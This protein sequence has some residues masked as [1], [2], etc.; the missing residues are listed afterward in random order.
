MKLGISYTPRLFAAFGLLALVGAVGLVSSRPARTAGGPIA[1]SVANTPL[2]VSSADSRDKQV[3]QLTQNMSFPAGQA[4]ATVSVYTV[5]T[6]KRLVI[7]GVSAYNS[8]AYPD[9]YSVTYGVSGGSQPGFVVRTFNVLPDAARLETGGSTLPLYADS[10]GEVLVQVSR[11]DPGSK[12]PFIVT[13]T[14]YLV[15]I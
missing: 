14:G 8:S 1:V 2:P 4:V 11:N 10:G 7:N 12:R 6:G 3:V 13:L 9:A 5:P 15:D